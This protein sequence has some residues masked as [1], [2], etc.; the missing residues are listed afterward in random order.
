MEMDHDMGML[1]GILKAATQG[2]A[3]GSRTWTPAEVRELIRAD[4]IDE[5]EAASSALSPKLANREAEAACLL[6]EI[7][8]QRRQ[9]DAAMAH[10]RAA[11]R[12]DP[13]SSAMSENMI[14]R[15]RCALPLKLAKTA[16]VDMPAS[17]AI[18]RIVAPS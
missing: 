12:I 16:P 17:A 15:N 10:F 8:F 6:G 5:A 4:R 14:S 7:A 11:L 2:W 9:D 1:A 3:G 13:A 18:S